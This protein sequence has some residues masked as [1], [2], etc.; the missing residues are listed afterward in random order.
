MSEEKTFLQKIEAIADASFQ[1]GVTAAITFIGGVVV[2]GLGGPIAGT[3]TAATFAYWKQRA[4]QNLIKMVQ[5]LA[6]ASRD[7]TRQISQS[8]NKLGE[9]RKKVFKE[10]FFPT[11]ADYVADEKEVEKVAHITEGLLYAIE[12]ETLEERTFN[13]LN[14]ILSQLRKIDLQVL[15]DYFENPFSPDKQEINYDE[16]KYIKSKLEK[17]GLIG[18]DRQ[19]KISNVLKE[20]ANNI[21]DLG[22]RMQTKVKLQNIQ[23]NYQVRTNISEHFRISALGNQ[24]VKFSGCARI[25]VNQ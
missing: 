2:P 12:N 13:E 21:H 10:A 24:M 8:W 14:D 18:S 7:D 15:N 19:E 20:I 6:D 3:L 16:L 23:R 25:F 5:H 1:P 9:N 4:E 22:N 17:M 11:T